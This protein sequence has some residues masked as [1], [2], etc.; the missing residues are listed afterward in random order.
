[1]A[2]SQQDMEITFVC[3]DDENYSYYAK[4]LES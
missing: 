1:L 4:L 2:K 3:F